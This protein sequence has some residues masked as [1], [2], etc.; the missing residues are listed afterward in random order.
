MNWTLVVAKNIPESP[1]L[2]C[3]Y[4][5]PLKS[6]LMCIIRKGLTNIKHPQIIL[7]SDNIMKEEKAYLKL[8]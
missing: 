1:E 7:A 3:I 4:Q 2:R 6:Y 8:N 5:S